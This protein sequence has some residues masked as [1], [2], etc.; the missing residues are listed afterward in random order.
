MSG[1]FEGAEVISTY[2]DAQAVEDGF[3]VAVG[4][5]NR[6]TAAAW[7][8]LEEVAQE[9]GG[10]SPPANWPVSLLLWFGGNV[11]L[12]LAVGLIEVNAAAARRIYEENI[13]G[14]IWNGE[15]LGKT[16]WLIPNEL[17]GLTLM[18]PEDY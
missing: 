4:N 1:L 11:A 16:V 9:Y 13:G 6:V 12:A 18:F 8:W 7:A 5:G 17:D 15:Y 2:T 10:G 3:L 14:G